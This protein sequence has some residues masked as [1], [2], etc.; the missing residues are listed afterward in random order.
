MPQW[1]PVTQRIRL[2]IL[3]ILAAATIAAGC[4][5]EANELN[6]RIDDAQEQVR[7]AQREVDPQAQLARV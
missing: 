5:D 7:D 6:E 1:R 3:P 4:G 2:L